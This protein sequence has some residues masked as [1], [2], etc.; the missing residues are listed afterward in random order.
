MLCRY[1]PLEEKDLAIWHL[2]LHISM[3]LCAV[4]V[5]LIY[6]VLIYNTKIN[7]I[8]WISQGK[9]KFEY[10]LHLC[11]V[12]LHINKY[13]FGIQLNTYIYI[14]YIRPIQILF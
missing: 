3:R 4:G 10:K 14:V 8:W 7:K 13:I 11:S 1:S 2:P 5:I 9:G 12:E 6:V